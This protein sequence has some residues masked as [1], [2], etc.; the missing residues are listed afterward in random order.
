MRKKI[1]AKGIL[2]GI[3]L[4][5]AISA[6]YGQQTLQEKLG[7]SK[8]TRLLIIHADDFGMCHS[9]NLATIKALE[10]GIVNSASI[11]T[12]C[13][14]FME[15][16]QYSKKNPKYDIGVHL[17][18]TNEWGRYKWS[19]VLGKSAVP[20]LVDEN[21]YMWEECADVAQHAKIDEL[22]KEMRAQIDKLIDAGVDPTHLDSHM[23]CMFWSREDI[24]KLYIDLG[25]AY[26]IP[27][28]LNREFFSYMNEDPKDAAN[29]IKYLDDPNLV[30]ANKV[31]MDP[32]A[33]SKEELF[34]YYD[35]SLNDLVP[36]LNVL[37]N[38]VGYNNDE[39][40]GI[41]AR[42]K[43]RQWDLDYFTDPACMENLKKQGVVM[44]TW[45]EV[46]KASKR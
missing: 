40:R 8:D 19:P 14:W 29:F 9:E 10:T 45:R 12:P 6:S 1:Q 44:V 39:L 22:E 11:M 4:I 3:V 13:P 46:N 38:H 34:K 21:G 16:A 31:M 27:V 32:G 30:V 36:G 26:G 23:G 15:A 25:K 33:K 43:I 42:A 5:F 41:T 35:A 20:S 7:Y 28:L 2:A 18:V 37:L 24:F 17:T